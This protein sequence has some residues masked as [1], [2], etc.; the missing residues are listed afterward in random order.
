VEDAATST[1]AGLFDL[2]AALLVSPATYRY[3]DTLHSF[4]WDNQHL[5]FAG[6]QT[7]LTKL[8]LPTPRT[9]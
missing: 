9:E 3:R 6:A 5:T 1:G 2:E 7:A 8:T 4:Y